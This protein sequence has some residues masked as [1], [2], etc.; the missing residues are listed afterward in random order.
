MPEIGRRSAG[1]DR[2]QRQG[3]AELAR[4]GTLACAARSNRPVCARKMNDNNF[5]RRERGLVARH[6]LR[7]P[8]DR[9]RRLGRAVGHAG[10]CRQ[11]PDAGD[12]RGDPGGRRGLSPPS[13][14]DHRHRRR[15]H[16]RHRR[17]AAR[18]AR[19][20]RIPDRRGALGRRGL[21]RHAG[22][23][24]RQRPHRA[25][26]EHRPGRGAG[27]GVPRRRGHRHA[28]GGPGTPRGRGLLRLPDRDRR[29]CPDR[30]HRGQRA[31]GARLRRVADLD[32]R[33]ARR[34][35]LHQGRRRRR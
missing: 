33:P 23:G 11:C 16:L 34:R 5:G 26:R 20:D 28:G 7:R 9:L 19:R 8:V 2:G 3:P 29:L 4:S 6:H 17:L 30:P 35:H 27:A 13:V 15:D 1:K 25:S 31:G 21:H 14:H 18:A 32:L 24:A 22:V 10:R 12:R